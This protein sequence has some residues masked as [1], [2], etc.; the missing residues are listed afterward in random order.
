MENEVSVG[1]APFPPSPRDAAGARP[2]MSCEAGAVLAVSAIA[3]HE[4]GHCVVARFLGLPVAGVTLV[5]SAD[6]AGL[7]FG[8][9]TDPN[10]VT[11]AMLREEA[12][13]HCND[14]TELLPLPGERRDC[15]ASWLVHAQT[16]VMESVAGF[17]AE[18]I[19]GFDRELEAGSTDY[20]VA[21]MYARSIVHSDEAVPSFVATCRA[22]AIKILR[23]HWQA[24]TDVA[25]ALEDRQT[26]TGVEIDAIIIEAEQRAVMLTEKQRRAAMTK[27]AKHAVFFNRLREIL[28]YD[29]DSGSFTRLISTS[30]NARAGHVVEYIDKASGYL[31]IRIGKQRYLAHR[32]AW[33][34]QTGVWPPH[35]IDHS[36][37]DRADN[38]W[39]NLRMATKGQNTCNRHARKD[40]ATG[41]KGVY[42]C[43]R[44]W[45]ADIK[46][47]RKH[48]HL[49]YFGTP[50]EASAAY[51]VAA[52]RYFG[53][54]SR[55][56]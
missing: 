37:M 30:S 21:G 13:R 50:E 9:D 47:N 17:A 4:A 22:D 40:S 42:K 54:F 3:V 2:V 36:N 43:A 24:V 20:A 5:A 26:L 52:Q 27:A 19:A 53:E 14:A 55:V 56:G 33:F 45:R 15:T 12:K 28:H 8:P 34:Y 29:P 32:L 35:Q 46:V 51:A 1:S 6:Y 16:L 10:K 48:H 31:R 41:I 23:D 18:T 11:A 49:G 25:M 38:R 7:C 44:K 39:V